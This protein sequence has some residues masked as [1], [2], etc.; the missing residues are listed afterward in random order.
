MKTIQKFLLLT[1][2]T[3]T[4]FLSASQA[5]IFPTGEFSPG[6]EADNK[7][8][9]DFMKK[10]N[11]EGGSVAVLKDGR[12]VYA[13]GFGYADKDK[14]R[15]ATPYTIYRIASVTKPITCIAIMQLVEQNK[16]KLDDKVFGANGLLPEYTDLITDN[17]LKQITVRHL[18]KHQGG[19][20]RKKDSKGNAYSPEF[21]PTINKKSEIEASEGAYTRKAVM[22]FMVKRKLE[23]DPGSRSEY[24][25]FGYFVLG[26]IIVKKSG[27]LYENYV[28]KYICD[29]LGIGSIQLGADAQN[30]ALAGES[31]YYGGGAYG[32]VMDMMDAHGGL[33][34]SAPALGLILRG[35][36]KDVPGKKLLKDATIDQMF[37]D[38]LCWGRNNTFK[39]Y[40]HNGKLSGTSSYMTLGD[41]GISVVALFNRTSG[42]N[43]LYSEMYTLMMDLS[44]NVSIPSHDLYNNDALY[45]KIKTSNYQAKFNELNGKGYRPTVIEG[46][47]ANNPMFDLI[48]RKDGKQ[49]VSFHGLTSAQYQAKF[50]E[51]QKPQYKGWDPA[52]IT[53][54]QEAG[55][56]LYAGS[57]VKTNNPKWVA[58]HD[59]S[60][61][62]FNT[63]NSKW[64]GQGYHLV[65]GSKTVK[66]G[67][68][69]IAA[70]WYK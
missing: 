35:V 63:E 59:M 29:P 22:D 25:N 38:G 15:A 21:E 67:K 1:L 2:I 68:T 56:V 50:D 70:V 53:V 31:V 26:R 5:Q 23:F 58:R 33:V 66:S 62:Q 42:D 65:K 28:K 7:K 60:D 51:L 52:D 13:K 4:A 64:T 3:L 17:R 41:N 57:F 39:T 20:D 12:L 48:F 24:S 16:I 10:W 8:V 37:N 36:D 14:E 30:G 55:K 45:W 49:A 43:D 11:I 61:A 34:A 44:K 54:Y 9:I 6:M 47:T 18:L 46:H 19:W 32:Y 40:Q 69:Y 27:M